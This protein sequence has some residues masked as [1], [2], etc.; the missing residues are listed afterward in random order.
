MGY[1]LDILKQKSDQ[2]YEL[3]GFFMCVFSR[4]YFPAAIKFNAEPALNHSIWLS[5]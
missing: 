1:F 4:N 3:V 2:L 5:L